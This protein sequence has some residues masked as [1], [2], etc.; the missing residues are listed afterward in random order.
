MPDVLLLSRIQ[1]GLTI[2]FHFIYPP[3][4]IGMSVVIAALYGLFLKTGDEA[5]E[6]S[7]D[8]FLKIFA[9]TFAIGVATGIVMEFEFGTNWAT[10]SR[11][12]GDIFGSPLAAEGVFAFFLE[13]SFLGILLYGRKRVGPKAHFVSAVLVSAGAHLS[14]LWILVANSWMQTPAGFRIEGTG[15][16]AR[17]RITD[18]WAMVFNPSTLQRF[19]HTVS[20]SWLAGSTLILAV[21]AWYLIQRQH[22]RLA[23]QTAKVSLLVAAAAALL[24]LGTGHQS[25]LQVSRTQPIKLA[26]M[27]GHWEDGQPMALNLVGLVDEANQRTFAIGIPGGVGILCSLNP[28]QPFKGLKSVPPADR[29]PLQAVFQSYHVMVGL[30]MALIAITLLGLWLWHRGWLETFRPAL[31]IF[32]ASP[33]LAEV[34]IQTGWFTAELG[35]QPWVVYNLLRT[36]D[37]LSK[38]VKAEAVLLSLVLFTLTYLLLFAIF[39]YLG[40]RQVL[41]GPASPAAK[42]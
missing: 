16:Q 11:Y 17:A 31:W 20:A 5:Y 23:S 28:K 34:A 21:C 15:M 1:F 13:S 14:A 3:L 26:A 2:G 32:M 40:L 6:R 42:P 22:V 33:L 36:S 29:P 18:F 24:Q 7:A 12:V 39:L 4:S 25:A 8:F 19:S 41:R 37:A 38:T 27:E 35:R 30:G 9:L 10:Y